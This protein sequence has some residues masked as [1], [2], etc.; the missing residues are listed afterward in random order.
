MSGHLWDLFYRHDVESFRTLLS[1]AGSGGS[2]PGHR[3]KFGSSIGGGGA[4]FG[5]SPASLGPSPIATQKQKKGYPLDVPLTRTDVNRRDR[6]GRTLLHLIA[7]SHEETTLEFATALLDSPLTDIYIQ[8][9]ESGWTA[10]HRAFYFGNVSVARMILHREAQD[11]LKNAAGRPLVK[12]KDHE[13]NGPYDVLFLSLHSAPSVARGSGDIPLGEDDA[14][15]VDEAGDLLEADTSMAPPAQKLGD[16][17]FTFGSNKNVTLGFGDEDDRQ[18]P[19]RVVLRRPE[20]LI[21]KQ[22]LE[23]KG[24]EPSTDVDAAQIPF[25]IR[26]LPITIRDVYMSKYHTAILT[27]DPESN[28]YVC[29]HG[30]GGRLGVGD[31]RTRYRFA[32]VT[33]GGLGSKTVVHVALGHHHT[34]AVTADGAVYSWGSN[35]HGQLGYQLANV[36]PN[37]EPLQLIP[38]QIYGMLK[39]ERIVGVAASRTHSV[40]FT[41]F[42]LFTFGKNDG[43]LGIVDADARSLVSQCIPRK[44]AASL[45][46]TAITKVAAI[47]RA[48]ICLLAN[49]EVWVFA[50][51]G[52]RRLTFPLD[53]FSN[54]FTGVHTIPSWEDTPN[55]ICHI[56]GGGDTI[57]ALSSMGEV[58]TCVVSQPTDVPTSGTST[59]NP[60]KIKGSFSH[61]K[62]IWSIKKGHMSARDVAVDQDGSIILATQA[63]TVWRRVRRPQAQRSATDEYQSKDFK[64]LRIPHLTRVAHVRASAFGAYAAIRLE[65]DVTRTSISDEGNLLSDA[66]SQLLPFVELTSDLPAA[67][68]K[69]M[70]SAKG[71]QSVALRRETD[72]PSPPITLSTGGW[73][74]PVHR[75]LLTGRS[76]VLNRCLKEPQELEFLHVDA[77]EHGLAIRFENLDPPVLFNLVY[78]LYTDEVVECWQFPTNARSR[79]VRADLMRL[80]H[81]L[82][83]PGLESAIRNVDGRRRLPDDMDVAFRHS[84]FFVDADVVIELED[85]Q[86]LAHSEILCQRCP[87]FDGLFHGRAGGLWLQG[88]T[89]SETGRVTVDLKHL[90]TEAFDFVLRHIYSDAGEEL[91][92]DIVCPKVADFLDRVLDVMAIAN[93]LLL[94]RLSLVCQKVVGQYGP[95]SVPL[96]KTVKADDRSPRPQRLRTY[97]RNRTQCCIGFSTCRAGL[98]LRESRGSTAERV[99]VVPHALGTT[100]TMPA[101]L[102]N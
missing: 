28:L 17:V 51:Y 85:G 80:A 26:S 97:Q 25:R 52:Y 14:S 70:N 81:L 71:V 98:H 76:P 66:Y 73:S 94:D 2:K 84:E 45:F 82:E 22:F 92:A 86:R 83:L 69:L 47:E 75:F 20:D 9:H 93:E 87:F 62:R 27:T 65:D 46:S 3:A 35:T 89:A 18:Y 57:C 102:T 59:T 4:S 67:V 33:T 101:T 99:C 50:N 56:T 96:S 10:L 44:V 37:E 43:Q 34:L 30:K 61:P 6:L 53:G 54:A 31:E 49:H 58:F 19:E 5:G 39:R 40:A 38:R 41:P 77:L 1:A 95:F 12:I 91:F 36:R 21:V 48:T 16:D 100:L 60:S 79:N 15:S 90:S 24:S 13:G 74:I 88:R 8:D 7:S 55:R 78:W 11:V 32:P 72:F 42:S 68:Q 64:F 23:S 63:G 29:G